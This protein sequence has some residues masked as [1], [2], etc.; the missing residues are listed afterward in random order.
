LIVGEGW[1]SD[2]RGFC[3]GQGVVD[4]DPE[5]PNGILDLTVPE[6]TSLWLQGHIAKYP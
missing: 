2:F 5:M 1:S 3:Q 6:P 4:V